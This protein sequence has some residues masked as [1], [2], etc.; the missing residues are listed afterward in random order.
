MKPV[1]EALLEHELARFVADLLEIA[2][3]GM[4]AGGKER[5]DG[6]ESEARFFGIGKALAATRGVVEIRAQLLPIETRERRGLFLA[7][8][9]RFDHRGD[10]D[11]GSGTDG[12]GSAK[13]R[14]GSGDRAER[15]K[16]TGA[17]DFR[18]FA[19]EAQ[20]AADG[21][22]GAVGFFAESAADVSD[23]VVDGLERHVGGQDSGE[24][25]LQS[26]AE[27]A[28]GDGEDEEPHQ[29][30][31]ERAA[32]M[33]TTV[34]QNEREAEKT[35][36][37]VATHP[38]LSAAEP[39][40]RNTLTRAEQRSENHEG[41]T[42][43]AEGEADGAA[44]ART[45]GGSARVAEINDGAEAENCERCVEPGTLGAVQSHGRGPWPFTAVKN[46]RGSTRWAA[47]W[48]QA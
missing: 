39:P 11:A 8:Q 41:E 26:S 31:G 34:E 42:D 44:A 33:E 2:Q 27:D 17:L 29:D 28:A 36:P 18:L 4:R 14:D 46:L 23:F 3:S 25:I 35:E 30:T 32:K 22:D 1:M 10:R 37:E 48:G 5:F 43:D 21:F 24:V 40:G 7:E 16:A 6:R 13:G 15:G 9:D 45:G 20:V 12:G 47:S 38:S 19:D